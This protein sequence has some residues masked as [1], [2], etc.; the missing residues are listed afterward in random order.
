MTDKDILFQEIQNNPEV[1]QTHFCHYGWEGTGTF[2]FWKFAQA[3]FDSAEALFDKFKQSKGDFAILDGLGVTMCFLYR[4]FVELSIKYL[5]LKFVCDSE[6]D[7]KNYLNNNHNLIKL[8]NAAKPELSTLR[9]R[10]GSSVS[11]GVL[12]HY[13]REFNTFDEDSMTMRYP[14]NKKLEPTN[15][16]TRLDIFNLHDRMQEMYSAFEGLDGDLENQ[17][18]QTLDPKE[19]EAFLKTYEELR[20][21]VYWF[22]DSMKPYAERESEGINFKDILDGLKTGKR[23]DNTMSVFEACSD[24]ELILLDTL[25]YTGGMVLCGELKLPLKPDDAKVDVVT[26]C[27]LNMK[28][29]HLEF[30]KPKN[31][32]INIYGKQPSTIIK[33]VSKAVT[34]ID[35]DK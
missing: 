1:D 17:L 20:G 3:Y 19:I 31:D 16:Q 10:V 27:L 14:V 22:I 5:Y 4:H 11:L 15:K 33:Y 7:F 2:A 29:D 8:W 12:E 35:W 30:G 18:K 13:I 28:R 9:E 26:R 25:Y 21:R 34:I 32:Q 23:K 24:D 6:E